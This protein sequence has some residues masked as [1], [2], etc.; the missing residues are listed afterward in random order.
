MKCGTLSNLY[1]VKWIKNFD[2]TLFKEI[3]ITFGYLNI[4]SV[5]IRSGAATY[6]EIIRFG[7]TI[8]LSG[9]ID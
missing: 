5:V 7:Q 2:G 3:K 4:S 6:T 9:K 8:P 1:V